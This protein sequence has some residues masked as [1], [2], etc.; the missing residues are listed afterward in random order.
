MRIFR[1][2]SP[3]TVEQRCAAAAPPATQ[4]PPKAHSRA[5]RARVCSIVWRAKQKLELDAAVIR[6]V[7]PSA[8][9]SAETK[10]AEAATPAEYSE[11]LSV[12]LRCRASA[13]AT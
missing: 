5:A 11:R 4:Q 6:G 13:T 7:A 8:S 3:H 12:R 9:S 10:P 2:V 1:L